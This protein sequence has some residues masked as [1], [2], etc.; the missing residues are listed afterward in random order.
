MPS[1]KFGSRYLVDRLPEGMKFGTLVGWALRCGNAEI[2]ERRVSLWSAEI[3]KGVKGFLTL[4][5]NMF[6]EH[7][8][9]FLAQV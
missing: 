9:Y 1:T 8:S 4:F 5:S 2:V 7:V 6:L 3:L